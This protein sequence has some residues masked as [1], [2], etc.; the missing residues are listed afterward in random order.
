MRRNFNNPAKWLDYGRGI[1][2]CVLHPNV[3]EDWQA[4]ARQAEDVLGR[5][6]PWA[7]PWLKI[8]AGLAWYRAGRMD[9]ALR[10]LEWAWEDQSEMT[11]GRA[12]LSLSLCY[13][14]LKKL[15]KAK[16]CLKKGLEAIERHFPGAKKGD[17]SP[18]WHEWLACD[19]L[20]REAETALGAASGKSPTTGPKAKD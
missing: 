5:S 13:S 4:L 2:P 16:D 8:S 14:H 15:D 10:N 1:A 19:L 6:D 18:T 3:E 17:L 20:R 11:S 7:V 12:L 9:D